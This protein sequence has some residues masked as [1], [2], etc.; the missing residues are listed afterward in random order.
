[1]K[2]HVPLNPLNKKHTFTCKIVLTVLNS[3][4][5]LSYLTEFIAALY[6]LKLRIHNVQPQLQYY[7]IQ[8]LNTRCIA[9][10]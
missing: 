10:E 1:M 8:L 4:Y 7:G 3:Q 5:L 2:S 6:K 9:N